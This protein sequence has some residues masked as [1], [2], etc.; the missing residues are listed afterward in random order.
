[1][2]SKLRLLGL[3]TRRFRLTVPFLAIS[4]FAASL[5]AVDGLTRNAINARYEALAGVNTALGGSPVDVALN[6]ANLSVTKGKKLEFGLGN[7]SIYN[8]YQDRFLDPNPDYVYSNDKKSTVQAP[9]PYVALKLPVTD[10]IDYGVALYIPGGAIG[11]VEEITRNTPNGQSLNQ[12]AGLN[13]PDPIGNSK[14]IKETNSNQFAVVKL[15][16]GISF[17]FG[18]L[19]LGAS[20]EA[21][22]GTQKL[23]QKYYDLTGT[24]E[25]PGQG[26]YYE[27]SKKAFTIGGVVGLNYALT[28]RFR[29]A[30]SYQTHSSIPLNGHY[31]IGLNDPTY[32]RSTGVSYNFDLPEKHSLGFSYGPE[33]LKVA[34]DLVYTNYGSY[35]RKANQKLEDPWLPTPLGNIAD[36]DAHLNFRSQAGFL[37]GLEH[38]LGDSWVYRLGYSYNTLA[39][40]SN[41][42]GGTTGG[43]F[44]LNHVFAGG[45]GYVFDK[46]SLDLGISYNGPKNHVTG[47]KGTDW[48]LSHSIKTGPAQFNSAGYSYSAEASILAVNIGATKSFD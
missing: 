22:Y 31:R 34:V 1:M 4:G 7:S 18:K 38:K 5:P 8:R 45:I 9:A 16:N 23:N 10:T 11:G 15:V 19:S 33:N 20:L 25:I 24:L 42:L 32:Y 37:I 30:Y 13:L 35:L 46:W 39:I 40:K 21:V 26:Y 6:P 41:G 28:E 47:G 27:S 12:W 17:R 43:F 2:I 29:V 14:Q 44:S 36:A 48:D 3:W